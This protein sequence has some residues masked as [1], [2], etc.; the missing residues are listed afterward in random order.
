LRPVLATTRSV[1]GELLL[2]AQNLH[3]AFGGVRAVDGVSLEVYSGEIVGVIGPNGAGKTTM[4]ELLAGFTRVDDGSVWFD[5][6]DVTW[7][8]PEQRGRLGL[9]RSFQDA[10]LF[11]TMPVLD[12]VQLALERV[13]PTRL[14]GSVLGFHGLERAK[15]R[16]AREIVSF[17]GLDPFRSKQVRELSTGTRRILELACMVAL[18]P[19]LLL[20]DEPSSGIAQRETEQLGRLLSELRAQFDITLLVIEHDIPL[21]MGLGDR[22]VAMAD[23]KVIAAGPPDTVR[24]DAGVVE[25]YL[26]GSLA[27]IERSGERTAAAGAGAT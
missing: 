9:I 17:M 27:A 7:M 13:A 22:I 20:L 5:G 1:G 12:V 24:E 26:G 19:S 15:E 11:P 25:S 18:E 8:T 14:V 23:G 6:R 4:F 2:N 3:K 16:R 10:A 21:I